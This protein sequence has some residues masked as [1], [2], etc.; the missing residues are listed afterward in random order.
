MPL[1]SLAPQWKTDLYNSA[2]G[3]LPAF[4]DSLIT[5]DLKEWDDFTIQLA[6]SI[7]AGTRTSTNIVST[8][9]LVYTTTNAYRGGVLA[10][11]GDIHFIPFSAVV[12]Q[13]I[14]KN[15]GINFDIGT[16]LHSHFN[17]F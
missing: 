2:H 14:N 13:K 9:S 8:Y 1:Y 7:K 6:R 12:G 11:N 17:K 10:P 4:D 3:T 5:S 16:C 15:S